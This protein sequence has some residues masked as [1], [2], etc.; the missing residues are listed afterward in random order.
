MRYSILVLLLCIAVSANAQ[1]SVN[2]S[3]PADG[4]VNVPLNVVL[5]FW[6]NAPVDTTVPVE[7]F[8]GYITNLPG[9]DAQWYSTDAETLYVHANLNPSTDYFVLLYWIPG[10]GTV[11]PPFGFRFTTNSQFSGVTVTGTVSST[12]SGVTPAYAFV[13]LS[14]NSPV[15]NAPNF[16]AATVADA[17]GSFTIPH[18]P[19]GVLYP[20]AAKDVTGDGDIDPSK[21]DAVGVAPTINVSG[22]N[23]SGVSI[24]MSQSGPLSFAAS[25][26]SAAVFQSAFL[27]G[28]YLRQVNCWRADSLGRSEDGAWN[29]V[30]YSPTLDSVAIVRPDPLGTALDQNNPNLINNKWWA[31]QARTI[32][33][34]GSAST[35]DVFIGKVEQAGGLAYRTQ[36][37]PGNFTFFRTLYLGQLNYTDLWQY[38]PDTVNFYWAAKYHFDIV[39]TQDSSA[40]QMAK[41][42]IGDYATGNIVATVAVNEGRSSGVPRAY[43]LDQNYP[44]PFNPSTRIEYALPSRSKVSLEVF[45]LL[46][47]KVATLVDGE[48]GAGMH[49][50][51]WAPAVSSGMYFYRLTAS[52]LTDQASFTQVRKMLFIK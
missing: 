52:S 27:P 7:Q 2:G 9:V 31:R 42:F 4:A 6:F 19:N 51:D 43:A 22:I 26:D 38:A 16:V 32:T 48:A 39:I 28:Y 10:P 35:A 11:T 44:N 45:N 29:F 41:F 49:S 33:N 18:V 8:Y 46:G 3:Y 12:I 47:E 13:G 37:V 24:T 20:V 23:V 30:Y 17:G 14:T 25:V 40:Q 50:A 1:F 15:N 21:G 5:K 36:S 34:P